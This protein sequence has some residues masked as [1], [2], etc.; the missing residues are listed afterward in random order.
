MTPTTVAGPSGALIMHRFPKKKRTDH[1]AR[2]FLIRR[3]IPFF[4]KI[5]SYPAGVYSSAT[6]I[7]LRKT[8]IAQV[9]NFILHA[10]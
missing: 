10:G 2:R 7:H 3:Q 5:K 8:K 4:T 9:D 6:T 1:Q